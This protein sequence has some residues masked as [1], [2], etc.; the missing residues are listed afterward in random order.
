VCIQY[1]RER[2]REREKQGERGEKKNKKKVNK[3][4]M[5]LKLRFYQL[6]LGCSNYIRCFNKPTGNHTNTHLAM[7]VHKRKTGRNQRT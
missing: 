7:E 2:D 4:C 3:F 1:E 6:K 5:I